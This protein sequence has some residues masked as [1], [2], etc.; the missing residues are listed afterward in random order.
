MEEKAKY[1]RVAEPNKE[2]LADLL[3]KAK[4]GGKT[5]KQ[6]AEE[7]GASQPAFSR[8]MH[9]S[10]KGPLADK[11]LKAIAE[12]ADPESDI[13]LD[14]L[15][16]A[17]GMARILDSSTVFR[18]SRAE[19]EKNFVRVVLVELERSGR[20]I[21]NESD[22]MFQIGTTFRFGPD[23]LVRARAGDK[24]SY[25]WA[26][27][28]FAPALGLFNGQNKD[29]D[30]YSERSMRV[31]GRR[32]IDKMGWILP[33]F[34]NSEMPIGKFSLVIADREIFDYLVTEYAENYRVPFEFSF[35][36][37]NTE[38]AVLEKEVVLKSP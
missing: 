18:D 34:Y 28:L 25:L 31:Y 24:G 33:L 15:M 37:C 1:I 29:E 12:H 26:F 38:K 22:K 4:G 6:F 10:Y 16:G 27:D 2:A 9:K 3:K 36:L 11:L 32:F 30:V 13:S 35:I 5:M 8:I 20:L 14:A 21:K 7:C 23:L 19:L 17:N